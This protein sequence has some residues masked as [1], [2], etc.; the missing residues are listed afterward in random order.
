LLP[1][2]YIHGSLREERNAPEH[3]SFMKESRAM[4]QEPLLLSKQL[5]PCYAILA[6]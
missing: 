5:C 6:V 3:K 1:F 4:M 2:L